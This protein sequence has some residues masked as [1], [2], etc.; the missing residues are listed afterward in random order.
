MPAVTA[1]KKKGQKNQFD[2]YIDGKKLIFLSGDKVVKSKLKPG[3]ELSE[4]ELNSLKAESAQDIYLN[5]CIRFASFRPRS[6]AETTKFIKRI[7]TPAVLVDTILNNLSHL[8]LINDLEF[9]KWW[10]DQRQTFRPK[11]TQVVSRELMQKG[12]DRETINQVNMVSSISEE[13][14]A[15]KAIAGKLSRLKSLPPKEFRQKAI[16]FLQRRGFK[17]ETIKSVI[18]DIEH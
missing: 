6:R 1:I 18:G 17:W 16:A 10:I 5:R 2:I 9:A 4:T 3:V 8:G 11:S 12:I 15:G 7:K 14:L 13:V